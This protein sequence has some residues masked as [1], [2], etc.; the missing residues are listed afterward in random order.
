MPARSGDLLDWKR[1]LQGASKDIHTQTVRV[2]DTVIF[3]EILPSG[4]RPAIN[5]HPVL[6]LAT[7]TLIMPAMASTTP[8]QRVYDH[9]LRLLVWEAGNPR[10][11]PELNPRSTLAGWLKDPPPDVVTSNCLETNDLEIASKMKKMERRCNVLTALVR[12]LLPLV[13]VRS[14]GLD[15]GRL[16]D[17][18]AK[19][20]VLRAI[21]SARKALPLATALKVLRLSPP[22]YRAWRRASRACGLDDRSS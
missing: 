18:A 11:F 1:S 22:R 10:L 7:R 16:P 3:A 2:P 19:A 12:L 13:R 8:R 15:G 20:R 14:V 6:D 4:S 21:D 9:R 5:P 17:G